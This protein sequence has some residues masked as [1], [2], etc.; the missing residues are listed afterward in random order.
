[1]MAVSSIDRRAYFVYRR[2]TMS[3]SETEGL[4]PPPRPQPD[5]A[6]V[7][8]PEAD[9]EPAQLAKARGHPARVQILSDP[10][11]VR[12][13]ANKKRCIDEVAEFALQFADVPWQAAP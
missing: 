2:K 10:V 13:S 8:G 4:C 11:L 1:M 3:A 5:D 7:D 6:P 12:R 9:A